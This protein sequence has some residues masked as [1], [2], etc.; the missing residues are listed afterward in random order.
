MSNEKLTDSQL[1]LKKRIEEK[2]AAKVHFE[3]RFS[4]EEQFT[5]R[6]VWEHLFTDEDGDLAK[7]L[8]EL[9]FIADR[10]RKKPMTEAQLSA[11]PPELQN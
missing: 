1:E 3:P 8:I 7:E 4:A 10:P 6:I 2:T 5:A 9:S 11:Y